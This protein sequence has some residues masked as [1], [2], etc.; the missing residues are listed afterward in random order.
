M[1]HVAATGCRRRHR[2]LHLTAAAC[3]RLQL[4]T[5]RLYGSGADLSLNSLADLLGSWCH[6][7]RADAGQQRQRLQQNGDNTGSSQR[8]VG[9]GLADLIGNTPLIRLKSLSEQT[10]CEV[11]ACWR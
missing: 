11:R 2:S 3:C 6:S 4:W 10:G 5:A 7:E 8:A 9:E 1:L